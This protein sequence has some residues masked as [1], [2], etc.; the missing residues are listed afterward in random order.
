M[1]TPG[2]CTRNKPKTLRG[3]EKAG[4]LGP[5]GAGG[6]E[7]A[8]RLGPRGPGGREKADRSGPWGPAGREKAGQSGPRGA[9]NGTA[10]GSLSWV[11]ASYPRLGAKKPESQKHQLL[12]FSRSVVSD[13]LRPHGL[14][15]TRLPCPPL[16]PG[17]C[18]N[19]CLLS[20]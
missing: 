9:G 5:R 12:S 19:S 10:V 1:K 8:G 17:A 3:G 20:Q 18:S 6:G 14:Q 13:S 15:H 16:P 7:K 2:C 11:F 4:R